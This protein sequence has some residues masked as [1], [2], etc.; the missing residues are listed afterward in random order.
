MKLS[1]AFLPITASLLSF[2]A[3][4]VQAQTNAPERPLIQL[5][6][7][8]EI[9]PRCDKGLAALRKQ[10]ASI[11]HQPKSRPSDTK[12]L[13]ADWNNLQMQLEDL[14]GPVEML[15]NVSPDKAVRTN[16]EACLV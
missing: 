13:F 11:E 2:L 12:K 10:V 9:G 4:S 3:Q 7:A 1:S 14:S 16:S 6:K 15:N 5:L 8:E